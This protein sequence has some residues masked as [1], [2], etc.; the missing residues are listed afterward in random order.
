MSDILETLPQYHFA[1]DEFCEAFRRFFTP[2]QITDIEV[3]CQGNTHCS[4]FSLFYDSDE[5]YIIHRD[6]GII[7]NWYKHLGRINTCNRPDFTLID[8]REFLRA[9]K[10][11]LIEEGKL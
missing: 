10:E 11:E 7:I 6:S 9:L 8:L 2:D 3:L 1:R 4:T 5:F